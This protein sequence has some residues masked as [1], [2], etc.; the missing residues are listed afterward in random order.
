MA[1]DTPA[2]TEELSLPVETFKDAAPLLRR[3]FT[4]EAVKFKVQAQIPKDNP[5]SGLI[6]CYIDARLVTDRLNTVCPQLWTDRYEPV[7]GSNALACFLTVDGIPR[8]DV[9]TGGDPKSLQSDAFKRAAVKFGIGVSLY[10][11]PQIFLNASERG[12]QDSS[13]APTLLVKTRGNKKVLTITDACD[14]FIRQQY[15]E[16]LKD[17]GIKAFGQPLDH[18]DVAGSAGDLLDVDQDAEPVEPAPSLEDEA[19]RAEIEKLYDGLTDAQRRRKP[20]LGLRKFKQQLAAATAEGEEALR[21]LK[22]EIEGR[23]K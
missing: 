20:A 23:A 11:V 17:V 6:V 12:E 10:A 4:S 3:P 9:G 5:R 15:A 16:W 21:K 13:G 8:T 22:G 18:G 14:H 2:A 1:D 7:P 19:L